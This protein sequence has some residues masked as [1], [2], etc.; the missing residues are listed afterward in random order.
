M[1]YVNYK[2]TRRRRAATLPQVEV[3]KRDTVRGRRSPWFDATPLPLES[4]WRW[5]A[6][7]LRLGEGG[8]ARFL[9]E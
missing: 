1:P 2:H 6:E 5:W 9:V 7:Y 4:H 3:V 8:I